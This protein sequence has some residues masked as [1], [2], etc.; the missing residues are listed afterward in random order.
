[1]AKAD[2]VVAQLSALVDKGDTDGVRALAAGGLYPA[3]DPVADA[4]DKLARVQLDGA[5]AEFHA[6]QRL[7][8]IVLWTTL[9]VSGAVLAVATLVG[10]SLVAIVGDVRNASDLIATGSAQIAHGNADLRQRTEEQASNLQQTA[11]S[12]EEL[13]A[14]VRHNADTARRASELADGASR[15][16]G[17]A[18]RWWARSSRRWTASPT[19][20]RR[21]PTSSA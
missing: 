9:C 4:I 21:S 2:E 1:M 20:R 5:A 10:L 14:T 18:G 13:T 11:A 15:V 19:A 7:Y 8:D 6:A 12:M 16:A 17:R 3:I